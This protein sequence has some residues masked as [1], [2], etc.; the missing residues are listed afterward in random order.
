MK[1]YIAPAI[2]MMTIETECII[3]QSRVMEMRNTENG[4]T[5]ESGTQG[6]TYNPIWGE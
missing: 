6:Q 2:T 1:R 4:N 5:E 3:A